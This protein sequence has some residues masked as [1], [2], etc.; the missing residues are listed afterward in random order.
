LQFKTIGFE[1]ARIDRSG[2]LLVGS[3][4]TAGSLSN[5]ANIIGGLFST[6][7]GSTSS[8]SGVAT[9][10]ATLP[11]VG[12]GLFLVSVGLG[13]SAVATYNPTALIRTSG[14]NAAQ[15]NLSTATTASISLS[16]LTV[17]F[18]QNSGGTNGWTWSII[19]LS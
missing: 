3:T 1:R 16:G 18:T 2:N 5:S 13:A 7:N 11:N 4:N 12:N 10:F 14:T 17:Q 19:R 9:S 6:F 8:A 15:T